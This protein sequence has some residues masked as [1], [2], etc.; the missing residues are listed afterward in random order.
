MIHHSSSDPVLIKKISL[1]VWTLRDEVE[2]RVKEKVDAI[3][4][5]ENAEVDLSDLKDAYT[6]KNTTTA[7]VIALSPAAPLDDSEDEMK[8]AM[9]EAMGG[10][11]EAASETEATTGDENTTEAATT[12]NE[13][14]VTPLFGANQA[15]GNLVDIH[16]EMP[17]LPD[18]KIFKGKTV[19]AEIGMDRIFF[20]TNKLF[21]EGQSIVIK[22]E[23]PKTFIM[24]ADVHYCRPFNLKSRVISQNNFQFRVMAKFSFL[25]EGERALLRQFLKSVEP[26]TQAAPP[27]QEAKA[28]KEADSD[29]S[30]LDD[31]I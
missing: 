2:A 11:D 23:I 7:E 26:E 5:N 27:V 22:F 10:G 6:K 9:E 1:K 29:F 8:R 13:S 30:E 3:A 4:D 15:D 18:D 14:N 20:F 12:N 31:L 24:N 16:L 19:L 17:P 28:E 25:K 21:T